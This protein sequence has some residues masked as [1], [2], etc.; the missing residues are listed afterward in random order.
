MSEKYS[1]IVVK[2]PKRETAEAAVA[3]VPEELVVGESEA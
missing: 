1:F 2:Y 3:A